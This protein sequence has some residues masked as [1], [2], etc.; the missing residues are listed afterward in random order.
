MTD[1]LRNYE[2]QNYYFQSNGRMAQQQ[3]VELD[4][5]TAYLASMERRYLTKW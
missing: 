2:N 3:F 1:E 4:E 5:G